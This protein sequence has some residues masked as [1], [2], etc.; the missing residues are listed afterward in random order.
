MKAD[1]KVIFYSVGRTIRTNS[2]DFDIAV[3]SIYV[4]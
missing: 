2:S 3:L 4:N 1:E